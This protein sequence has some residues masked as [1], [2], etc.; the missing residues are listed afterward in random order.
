MTEQLVCE[1]LCKRSGVEAMRYGASEEDIRGYIAAHPDEFPRYGA[2]EDEIAEW[3]SVQK[4]K[5]S[6]A[7]L[8]ARLRKGR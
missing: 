3:K 4:E 8:V 7:P 2:T 5:G 6:L 1:E